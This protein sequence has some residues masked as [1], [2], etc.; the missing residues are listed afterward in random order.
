MENHKISFNSHDCQKYSQDYEKSTDEKLI[1]DEKLVKD[2]SL[3]L[4]EPKSTDE[5]HI[6]D[7]SL[8]PSE[9]K[10]TVLKP[11]DSAAVE[12]FWTKK[13][14]AEKSDQGTKLENFSHPSCR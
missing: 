11:D 14:K 12:R 7:V 9:L 8:N 3:N 1:K 5:N 2:V 4:S 6:K 13:L 10:S